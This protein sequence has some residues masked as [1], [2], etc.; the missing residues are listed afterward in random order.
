GGKSG[1]GG[2]VLY[3]WGNP[4]AYFAG[5]PADQKLFGQHDPHWIPAGLPGAGNILIF[6]NGSHRDGRPFS[7][8][9]EIRPP[10][11]AD[12]TYQLDADAPYGPEG[13]AW[14]YEDPSWLFSERV[15]G[16]QRLP[17]GN[18]LIC[19]GESGRV[20][21]VSPQ[22]RIVWD[23]QNPLGAADPNG[24]PGPGGPPGSAGRPNGAPG[25]QP[26]NDRFPPGAGP[27][28]GAPG[29]GGGGPG[30]L[31]GAAMFRANRYAPDYPAFR[32]RDLNQTNQK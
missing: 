6:N 12:G 11:K 22:G 29:P 24:P 31:N 5:T 28:D 30:P 13:S 18:T 2:D 20:T 14:H 25:R 17:N 32:G 26:P 21:E 16:A 19:E 23:Y 7:S 3:R 9:E 8:I 15:S 4:F 1:R 27:P 10:L